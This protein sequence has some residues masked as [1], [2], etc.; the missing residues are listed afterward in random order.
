MNLLA[1]RASLSDR[2][3][4]LSPLDGFTAKRERRDHSAQPA[5]AGPRGPAQHNPGRST[6]A[7]KRHPPTLRREDIA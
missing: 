7:I 5:D 1:K 3:P 4:A 2:T 6:D